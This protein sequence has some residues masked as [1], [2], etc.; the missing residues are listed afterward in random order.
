MSDLDKRLQAHISCLGLSKR[1]YNCLIQ[2]GVTTIESMV[3]L[4]AATLLSFKQL[5]KKTKDEILAFIEKEA[6]DNAILN[7]IDLNRKKESQKWHGSLL[8]YAVG[9][10][11]D[12][13][14]FHIVS[15]CGDTVFDLP[16]AKL[17]LSFRSYN[18]LIQE[19]VSTFMDLIKMPIDSLCYIKNL[20][21]KSHDEILDVIRYHVSFDDFPLRK[22]DT[23][24]VDFL[25]EDF[26]GEIFKNQF[27]EIRNKAYLF[28]SE[29]NENVELTD[30]LF[31]R[32][33]ADD[34]FWNLFLG[35]IKL[36]LNL[37]VLCDYN[38]FDDIFQN[39]LAVIQ[40]QTID[41][42]LQN[43]VVEI[44]YNKYVLKKPSFGEFVL[45]S[46]NEKNRVI[47]QN[48]VKGIA[49][50]ETA[51]QL[52]VSHERIRQKIRA[53]MDKVPSVKEDIYVY[54]LSDYCSKADVLTEVFSLDAYS[55]YY[56][57]SKLKGDCN[58]LQDS[59]TDERIPSEVR[60]NIEKYLMRDYIE[61][62]GGRIPRKREPIFHYVL[63][64]YCQEYTTPDEFK[65]KYDV[66]LEEFVGDYDEDL[67]CY[68]SFKIKLSK[69]EN[70]LWVQGEKFRYFEI[71]DSDFSD[72]LKTINFES[73]KDVEISTRYFTIRYRDELEDFDIHDEY[74]LHNL[75]RKKLDGKQGFAF[76]RMPCMKI[77][78][79][80]RKD[81]LLRLLHQESPIEADDLASKYE[82]LYGVKVSVFNTSY[83]PILQKYLHKGVYS[84]NHISLTENELD[85]LENTLQ[86]KIYDL[87]QV[88]EWFANRFSASR[89]VAFNAYSLKRIN[90]YIASNLIYHS[91]KEGFDT[92]F[93]ENMMNSDVVDFSGKEWLL[94]NRCVYSYLYRM[95]RSHEFLEFAPNKF[96]SFSKLSGVIGDVDILTDFAESAERFSA[97]KI[98]TIKS[99]RLAGFRHKLDSL[100][101]EN[102]FYES[103]LKTAPNLK[104]VPFGNGFLFADSSVNV[105]PSQLIRS[106]VEDKSMVN[107]YD[108]LELLKFE[109]GICTNKFKVIEFA[110]FANVFYSNSMEKLYID[111]ET[112]I[113]DL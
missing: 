101:F 75:L 24:S 96:I 99:L 12:F 9:S 73:L 108:L 105:R 80:S 53:Y 39:R 7:E 19:G 76:L 106:I 47:I 34:L 57:K 56:L 64:H 6:I 72:M 70:C 81:Q 66:F 31:Y 88:K 109:Y 102:F 25:I 27:E 77:G 44:L 54:L 86:D 30:D 43:G 23:A 29:Q 49:L 60:R 89:L 21:K 83:A 100:G 71:S 65:K 97:G 22:I 1:A 8:M 45:S 112:F 98:F 2:N 91:E 61:V 10:E 38:A 78:N 110:Q 4:D 46:D 84:V 94:Q 16:L 90:W 28:L 95:K 58:C 55:R 17:G 85:F 62:D 93:R 20:G 33:V 11:N 18:A 32:F 103:I 14:K 48:S 59:L 37:E 36:K 26:Q 68:E 52:G 41:K 42:A 79:A 111:Y 51:N 35:K 92:F 67:E 69:N 5:G 3:K 50:R 104:H 74:E 40:R 15:G 107:V 13:L 63:K 82:D 87:T 113:G